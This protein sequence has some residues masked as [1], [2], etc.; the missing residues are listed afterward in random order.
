M[1]DK[2]AELVEKLQASLNLRRETALRL[3][4]IPDDR[5]HEELYRMANGEVIDYRPGTWRTLWLRIPIGKYSLDD[6]LIALDALAETGTQRAFYFLKEIIKVDASSGLGAEYQ[7]A[8]R[9]GRIDPDT[10]D[11][12]H[13]Y[14]YCGARGHLREV[15]LSGDSLVRDKVEKAVQRAK[16]IF[17]QPK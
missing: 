6:Q 5:A 4:T 10:Y 9:D 3:A 1:T 15:L 12:Y 16:E 2:I 17:C 7:Y 11:D 13:I 14:E 8:V